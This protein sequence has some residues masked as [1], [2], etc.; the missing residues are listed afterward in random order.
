MYS[1]QQDQ[2]GSISPVILLSIQR[3]T[4]DT[5]AFKGLYIFLYII[6]GIWFKALSWKQNMVA[7]S[8]RQIPFSFLIV[9][10]NEDHSWAR[11]D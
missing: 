9:Y 1:P 2:D 8:Y 7:W 3:N 6:L 4:G 5:L 11:C 10:R